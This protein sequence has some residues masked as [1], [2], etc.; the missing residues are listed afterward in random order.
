MFKGKIKAKIY[1]SKDDPA[2]NLFFD[3]IIPQIIPEYKPIKL[4][5]LGLIVKKKCKTEMYESL[6]HSLR[7]IQ[8]VKLAGSKAIYIE[9]E[10]MKVSEPNTFVQDPLRQVAHSLCITDCLIHTKS[11]LDSMAVFLTD[12]LVLE[13]KKGDRDFKKDPFRRSICQNDEYL[14]HKIKK[15]EPWFLELQKIRMNGFIL[16]LLNRFLLKE[17]VRLDCCLYP[18]ILLQASKKEIRD[19]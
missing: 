4:A 10:I 9:Q 19:Y 8:W 16:K 14:K 17:K 12:L 2:L 18:K 3:Q 13:W 5:T 6:R 1:G 7:K 11:A 15:L